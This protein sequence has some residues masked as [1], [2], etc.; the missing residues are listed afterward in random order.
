MTR[1]IQQIKI[2]TTSYPQ[3]PNDYAGRFVAEMA[4]R[5]C[6][7][8][9]SVQ[10]IYP[11]ITHQPQSQTQYF[12]DDQFEKSPKHCPYP[13]QTTLFQ[14][15]G[16]PDWLETHPIAQ[17][18]EIPRVA[19]PLMITLNHILKSKI[20]QR[21]QETTLWIA[22]WLLPNALALA[23]LNAHKQLK[24][25]AYVHGGDLALLEKLPGRSLIA[26]FLV[27]RIDRFVFVSEDLKK[28]F[29]KILNQSNTQQSKNRFYVK[30]MG[31][32]QPKP[33]LEAKFLYQTLKQDRLC[34]TSIGRLV[35]IKGLSLL[36][37]ALGQIKSQLPHFCWLIAGHGPEKLKILQAAQNAG[38]VLGQDFIF[39]GQISASQREA[40]LSITDLFVLS[41]IEHQQRTEGMPVSLLEA[42]CAGVNV[43]SSQTGGASEI[44]ELNVNLFKAN[45]LQ[46][47]KSKL[48]ALLNDEKDR[49][50]QIIRLANLKNQFLW[51]Q[52]IQDH[53][54]ICI[55]LK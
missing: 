1:P 33:D 36:A 32:Y 40:L 2:L 37:T 43:L 25:V 38:L 10:V 34:I 27:E 28:R 11:K 13:T 24:I 53:W 19:L 46:D 15:Q 51:D 12:D 4:E 50:D 35:P 5:F 8:A 31:V 23:L 20:S 41:S 6:E 14:Q 29:E 55:G 16:A 39:L 45:D 17:M 52:I 18:I 3:D 21:Q 22:H 47:L 30:A 9:T 26:S 44:L 7:F 49:L 54:E 48:L 42:I